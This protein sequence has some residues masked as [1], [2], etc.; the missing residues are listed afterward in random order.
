MPGVTLLVGLWDVFMSEGVASPSALFTF[1]VCHSLFN[2]LRRLYIHSRVNGTNFIV[3]AARVGQ[4]AQTR[5]SSA[6]VVL[7]PDS[8]TA[9][10]DHN[11][12]GGGWRRVHALD[13]LHMPA[14]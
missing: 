4:H 1:L 9:T 13:G 11:G 7:V 6:P 14:L 5:D 8:H 3:V 2:T 10:R 12:W